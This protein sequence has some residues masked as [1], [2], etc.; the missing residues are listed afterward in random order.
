[1]KAMQF[2]PATLTV[3]EGD[4]VEWRNEDFFPHTATS[5]GIFDSAAI[6]AQKRWRYKAVTRG[7]YPYICTLHPT[8]KGMLVVD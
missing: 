7:T 1:M 5:R 8:M 3:R 6:D 2:V 4:I